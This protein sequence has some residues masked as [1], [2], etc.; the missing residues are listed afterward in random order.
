M[1]DQHLPARIILKKNE[2][3]RVVKGHPW[4]FSNEIQEIT[5]GPA[6]GDVVEVVSAG[7]KVVGIGFYNPHSLI[8][9]R[10]L[11]RM[12]EEIDAAFFQ[13]RL[14]RALE[15]RLR[16]Y[17]DADA[18][19]LVHG[20]SD[21]LPGLV[22][23]RFKDHLSVQTLSYG[24]D[25]RLSTICDVLE[26]LLHPAAII[27]RNE[28]SLRTMEH[29]PPR[30]GVLRGTPAGRIVFSENG[31]LYEID[32]MGGQKTGF[33][34]DQRENR[35][36]VARLCRNARV[37]DC[38][39]NDGGFALNAA[40]G[41]AESVVGIDSSNEAVAAAKRN[42]EL[43]NFVTTSFCCEEATDAL[44]RFG[45]EGKTFDVAILDPPSFTRNKKSVPSARQ[46][47]REL[48]ARALRLVKTG[49]YLATA[50]CSHHIEP[51]AFLDDLTVAARKSNK[52]LQMIEWR[53]AS[54][55]HPTIPTVPE[56]S[57]LKFAVFRVGT[58]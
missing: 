37:L 46:G 13:K 32:P 22:I 51:Q 18:F 17:P 49:G 38:Y 55:D 44:N 24:M 21:Y 52:R 7:R 47:Y 50:S 36:L 6:I 28:T 56:T 40:R 30:K 35:L 15:L 19:R 39:C 26:E 9:V 2:D 16:L 58:V 54:P 29:L 42:A 53:G 8:A 33:F 14:E 34:L 5:G 27:E 3:L 12:L 11:S 43:N 57:Y 10:L 1:N 41:G 48:N 25:A 4:V 20:E 23:D 45:N 31:I